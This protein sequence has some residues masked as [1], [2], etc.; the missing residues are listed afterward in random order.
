MKRIGLT[1]GVG[2]GKSVV[3]EILRIMGFSV[4]NSDA[5]AKRLMFNSLILRQ[6]LISSFGDSTYTDEG[7]NRAYL[8]DLVFQD[9]QKLRRL[10]EIV[11]PVVRADFLAWCEHQSADLIFVESAILFESGLANHLH[12]VVCVDAPEIDRLARV[13]R[14]DGLSNTQITQRMAAQMQRSELLKNS[15][16]VLCNDESTLLL[17]QIEEIIAALRRS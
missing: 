2:S 7:L 3:A 5:E 15:D 16:Y 12:R 13:R 17:P 14:R 11:H 10:N 8:A 1:G 9:P 6:Q 4:Y